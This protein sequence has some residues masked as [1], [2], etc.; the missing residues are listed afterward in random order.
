MEQT[1]GY[2]D[3]HPKAEGRTLP[4]TFRAKLAVRDE[5]T[6]LMETM[7]NVCMDGY[8]PVASLEFDAYDPDTF[9]PAGTFIVVQYVG[10]DGVSSYVS[11]FFRDGVHGRQYEKLIDIEG[12]P[13]SEKGDWKF[14]DVHAVPCGLEDLEFHNKPNNT[15]KI[16]HAKLFLRSNG[17][18]GLI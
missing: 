2:W 16:L 13:A 10:I 3:Q 9:G 5:L 11:H 15:S 7:P 6:E 8:V 1:I 4:S 17:Q 18:D 12:D 14:H